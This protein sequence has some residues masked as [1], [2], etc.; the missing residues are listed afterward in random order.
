[1]TAIAQTP[2]PGQAQ[3]RRPTP[4]RTK[5]RILVIGETKGFQHDSVPVAM[6]YI[7]K[8]GHDTGLWDAYLRTDTELL[9]KKNIGANAKTLPDFD[10]VV[11]DSTTGELD[12]RDDQK[13]DLL[14]FVHDDGKGLVGVHAAADCNYKWDAWADMLG[15]WFDQH[16]WMTFEAPIIREDSDFPATRHFPKAFVKRD[17]IYQL[18]NWSR[19][20]VNVLLRLDETKLSYEN[21]P[22]I[23][24]EDRDFAVAFAKMYGKGRVFYSTLGHTNEAWDDPDVQKM[25]FEAIRWTLGMTEGSTASHPRREQ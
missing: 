13:A 18:K 15:G 11:F 3:A 5:K 4:P 17:E 14:S 9:T 24:R 8:W 22:R 1:M 10:A 16:P 23:H 25:Y 2:A 7:W 20:K 19:D 21:N 12:L 6:A